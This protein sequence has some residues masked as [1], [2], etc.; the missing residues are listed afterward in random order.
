M[1]APRTV[2]LA[3]PQDTR[4]LMRLT[5]YK[6]ILA[7]T[8]A[9]SETLHYRNRC[10]VT[11]VEGVRVEARCQYPRTGQLAHV[12]TTTQPGL[13]QVTIPFTNKKQILASGNVRNCYFSAAAPPATCP[14]KTLARDLGPDSLSRELALARKSQ[15]IQEVALAGPPKD[16]FLHFALRSRIGS[17]RR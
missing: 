8:R 16:I 11:L 17:G 13:V 7:R 9:T 5:Q 15:M 1:F 12:Q 2:R 3:N 14:G 10:T 4:H 6:S